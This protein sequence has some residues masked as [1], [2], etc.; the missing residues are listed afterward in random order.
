MRNRYPGKCS[1]CGDEVAAG[2][3]HFEHHR[4]RWRHTECAI[5]DRHHESLKGV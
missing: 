4:G 3:G 1:R 2:D 5:W